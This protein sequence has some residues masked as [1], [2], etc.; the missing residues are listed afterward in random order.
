MQCV[1]VQCSALQCS[2]VQCYAVQCYAVQCGA[3]RCYA[4]QCYAV[5]CGPDRP[6]GNPSP[7][8]ASA[9]IR[10]EF[11]SELGMKFGSGALRR[12]SS[13]RRWAVGANN[14]RCRPQQ[15]W[16]ATSNAARRHWIRSVQLNCRTCWRHFAQRLRQKQTHSPKS[17]MPVLTLSREILQGYPRQ[18]GCSSCRHL[19]IS[20][21]RL[22]VFSSSRQRTRS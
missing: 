21:S 13:Q 5:R 4:V 14:W 17:S 10:C 7:V 12:R 8:Q 6:N 3:V 20:S 18:N 16:C 22:P 11:W 2:A 9:Q 15:G 1:A 19:V